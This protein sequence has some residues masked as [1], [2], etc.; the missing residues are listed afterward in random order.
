MEPTDPIARIYAHRSASFGRRLLRLR[1]RSNWFSYARGGV[2]LLATTC[3]VTAI[4]GSTLR[5]VFFALSAGLAVGFVFLVVRHEAVWAAAEQCRALGII[6]DHALFRVLRDWDRLPMPGIVAEPNDPPLARDLDL[7][8][9]SSLV[10]LLAGGG[11]T[12]LGRRLL[13]G[14]LLDPAEPEAI[15]ARQQAVAELAGELSRRQRFVELGQHLGDDAGASERFL[16]WAEDEPWLATRTWLRWIARVAPVVLLTS[17]VAQYMGL[18]PVSLWMAVLFFNVALSLLLAGKLREIFNRVSYRAGEIEHYSAMFALVGS[19]PAKTVL[20]KQIEA[21]MNHSKHGATARLGRLAR[22]LTLA[23]LRF[24]SMVHG[25]MQAFTLWDF[26]VVDA[27]ERWQ[28]QSG[29]HAR[30]WF[31]GLANWDALA[32]LAT[33]AHDNPGWTF[34]EIG[35]PDDVAVV[36]ARGL[37]HPLLA[38][39]ARVVNDV[40][41]GP[42]GTFLLVT[43]SN[44]SGKSTLLRAI[45]LNAVLAQ[46][47][48]PVAAE[49]FRLPPVVIATSMRV[50]DSLADGTSLFLAEL[51]R[52]KQVVDIAGRQQSAGQKRRLLF[53]LDEILHGTNSVERQIA[54][55]RVMLHLLKQ[56]AIGAISTH[57]LA[58]A[59]VAP[60]DTANRAVHFQECFRVTAAG[61]SMTFDYLLRPGLATTT[62]ALQLLEIVGLGP[63][64]EAES[65]TTSGSHRVN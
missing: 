61:R 54:V 23:D 38:A 3:L 62:N 46:A 6:N 8:G 30:Q 64:D 50:E 56:G 63:A 22:L 25:V 15:A 39:S 58:L 37:G 28:A 44:M 1:R 26:H 11:A 52:L 41:V 55:R 45:G 43:G 20:L 14:W 47:G 27:I 31:A 24:S 51:K 13:R 33:L 29:T 57:D 60:L 7:F 59:N 65:P 21:D 9:R 18:L 17:A 10:Q 36:A 42:P 48:G 35:D 19:R 53:L 16:A 40:S 5:E 32:S 49:S 12:A 34:A 4:F 2:A